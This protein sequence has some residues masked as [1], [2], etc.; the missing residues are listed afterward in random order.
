MIGGRGRAASRGR[1]IGSA[2][3]G[4]RSIGNPR[5]NLQSAICSLQSTHAPVH[6]HHEGSG[7]GPPARPRRAERHLALVL[8]RR[9]DRRA[10]LERRGQE[11]AAAHHVGGGPVV[12]RR[13]LACRGDLDRDAAPGAEARSVQDRA[14]QRRG[15]RR[16]DQGAPAPVRRDQREVRRGSVTRGDGEGP[17]GAGQGPGSDRGGQRLGPRLA[18]RA[19]DGRAAPAAAGRRR[20]DA[21]GR[22]APPGRALPAAAAIAGPAA[23]RRADEPSRRRVGRVAR[24]LPE[25]LPGHRRGGDARSLL[26]RQRR[27]LDP[28]ARSRLGHSL[29][30]ELL[31]VARAE[32]GTARAGGEVRDQAPAHAG[33][34]AR[35]DPHV[36]A[37]APGQGQGAPQ[38]L[39]GHAEGRDHQE[40]RP[41]RDLH[42]A[43]PAPRRHR[44]RSPRPAEGVRRHA[45]DG[46]R[47]FHAAA[48]RHRRRDRPERR[49]QDHAVP[50]DHREGSSRTPG[51][52]GSARR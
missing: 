5:S 37:R 32:A 18:R 11:L 21:L 24:A 15:R 23:P 25:G 2:P 31:V 19:R 22:R 16:R 51:R 36:A 34:R 27:R 4:N 52:S 10:R 42:R 8:L 40:D 38:R 45:A 41:G 30:R 14:R 6:L 44:R 29:G 48:R 20:H 17:R 47:E 35:V 43:R 28:R 12:R 3:I 13:G 46:R 49:R 50:D 7:E 1:R 9:E 39:R 26:P 33:A